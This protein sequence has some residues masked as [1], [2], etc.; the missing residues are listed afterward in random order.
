MLLLFYLHYGYSLSVNFIPI[1][2]TAAAVRPSPLSQLPSPTPALPAACYPGSPRNTSLMSF[3]VSP[4]ALMAPS[5][6]PAFLM[7]PLHDCPLVL[8]QG[9]PPLP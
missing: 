2:A 6:S 5:G 4:T 7:G 9:P 1:L 3:M 8:L